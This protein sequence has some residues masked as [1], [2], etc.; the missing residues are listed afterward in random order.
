MTQEQ[1]FD[2]GY[3][4]VKGWTKNVDI[5]EKEYIVIPINCSL[6]WY[7]A[8]VYNPVALVQ[9]AQQANVDEHTAAHASVIEVEDEFENVENV[10]DVGPMNESVDAMDIDTPEESDNQAMMAQQAALNPSCPP[11]PGP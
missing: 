9:R 10:S 11:S 5:F 7:L 4:R 2:K 8:I 3:D 1:L 6:H